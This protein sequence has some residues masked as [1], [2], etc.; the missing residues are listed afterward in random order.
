[1]FTS[2]DKA[3]VAIIMAALWLINEYWG[4]GWYGHVS[5]EAV[6]VGLAALTPLAVWLV[7]NKYASIVTRVAP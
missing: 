4:L 2:Y 6:S 3:I 5:E 1:M 7:P